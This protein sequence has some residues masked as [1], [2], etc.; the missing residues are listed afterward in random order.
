MYKRQVLS[1]TFFLTI[2]ADLTVAVEVGVLLSA[3][4]F[5][6][7]MSDNTSLKDSNEDALGELRAKLPP[8]VEAFKLDGPLFFGA[9]GA[10]VEA[11]ESMSAQ[12][13]A[14]ILNMKDVPY[15]DSSGIAA[16]LDVI[17]KLRKAKIL[18]LIHI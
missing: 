2:F 5:M 11:L 14:L 3:I 8:N 12:P 13:K 18:S 6:K 4:L 17:V 16:L 1:L 7:A 15:I 9:A 10:F